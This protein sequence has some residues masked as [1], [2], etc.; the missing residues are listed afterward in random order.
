MENA[1]Y[2]SETG[3]E[4]LANTEHGPAILNAGPDF[5]LSVQRTIPE[6]LFGVRVYHGVEANIMDYEGNIDIRKGYLKMTDFVIASMHDI[7]VEPAS[8]EEH[9]AGY[10]GVLENPYVDVIGHPGTPAFDMDRE[11]FVKAVRR[12]N[13]LV[14]VN[15]HSFR[16]R[17]GSAERCGEIVRLCSQYDVRV[18]V[19]SDAHF[20][21][22]VGGFENALRILE[23]NA[24]PPELVV[25]RTRKTMD[26]YLKER[27]RRLS[28]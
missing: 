23:E 19:S 17:P 7:V 2:A 20:C 24:F 11:A 1:K 22:S 10:E 8:R 3:L 27:Q 5:C 25:N 6:E 4:G 18:V 12:E 13:K 21:M 16:F 9:L 28:I 26:A 15:N 14:E